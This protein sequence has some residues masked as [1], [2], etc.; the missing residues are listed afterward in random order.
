M[1]RTTPRR[2]FS[3]RCRPTG[4]LL[5]PGSFFQRVHFFSRLC[6]P[7][8]KTAIILLCSLIWVSASFFHQGPESRLQ[9][10]GLPPCL[11]WPTGYLPPERGDVRPSLRAE[12]RREL[13]DA[14]GDGM[15][16]T[17]TAAGQSTPT[18]RCTRSLSACGGSRGNRGGQNGRG[19]PE[20][21]AQA[22][23]VGGQAGRGAW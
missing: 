9:G 11:R 7:V 4:V 1:T 8:L 17:R 14:E 3:G 18:I 5:H 12:S 13:G 10:P 16:V 22:A 19:N 21:H 6:C 2:M 15:P 23:R 20:P